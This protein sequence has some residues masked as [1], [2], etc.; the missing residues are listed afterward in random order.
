VFL[1]S[2]QLCYIPFKWFE[3]DKSADIYVCDFY[4][5]VFDGHVFGWRQV[6]HCGY[7]SLY[8]LSLYEF[9]SSLSMQVACEFKGKRCLE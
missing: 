6:G 7:F 5:I 8:E 2:E 9:G 4:G 3:Q 1:Q